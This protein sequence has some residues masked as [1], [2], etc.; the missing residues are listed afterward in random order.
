MTS[1]E[2]GTTLR[3][4]N[5]GE[6][7]P[8]TLSCEELVQLLVREGARVLA[9]PEHGVFLEVRRRLIFLRRGPVIGRIELRDALHAA[10][11]GPGRFDRVVAE[12]RRDAS[13]VCETAS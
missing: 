13:L 5:E 7:G 10:E 12:I 9:K 1:V 3:A 6:N 4:P 2:N 8:E 11:I